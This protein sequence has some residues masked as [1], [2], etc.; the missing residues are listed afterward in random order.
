MMGQRRSSTLPLKHPPASVPSSSPLPAVLEAPPYAEA[1]AELK[2]AEPSPV[3]GAIAA[4]AAQPACNGT[5]NGGATSPRAAAISSA[6]TERYVSV[7]AN[8]RPADTHYLER[9]TGLNRAMLLQPLPDAQK[10]GRGRGRGG[11]Q[12]APTDR[13]PRRGNT[14]STGLR[15]MKE[16]PQA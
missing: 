1:E 12:G 10:G 8:G 13:S 5:A 7:V 11:R 14:N 2:P 6:D 3:V 15:Y 16:A 4:A 9:P